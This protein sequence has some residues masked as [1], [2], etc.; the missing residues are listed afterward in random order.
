M[1]YAGSR[2]T[3]ITF[4]ISE[5]KQP[6][7]NPFKNWVLGVIWNG[8][9]LCCG[10]KI[11]LCLLRTFSKGI[12]GIQAVKLVHF[13]VRDTQI[14]FEISELKHP[15]GNPFKNC[16]LGV[17]WSGQKLGRCHRMIFVASG[18]FGRSPDRYFSEFGS[19][20]ASRMTDLGE[21]DEPYNVIP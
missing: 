3:Q 9:K 14:T 18:S 19:E 8:K 7:G 4:E 10:F 16:V 6:I 5:L 21:H 11:I 15:I 12:F 2:D 13:S 20:A 1:V 17:I